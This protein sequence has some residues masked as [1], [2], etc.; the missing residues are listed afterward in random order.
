MPWLHCQWKPPT[1][2]YTR[3]R[4]FFPGLLY[5]DPLYCLG[6]ANCTH[7]LSIVNNNTPATSNPQDCHWRR[8][9]RKPYVV[10]NELGGWSNPTPTFPSSLPPKHD[11]LVGNVLTFLKICV[12]ATYRFVPILQERITVV[13][14]N[15]SYVECDEL[16]CKWRNPR[17]DVGRR[18][19]RTKDW[20]KNIMMDEI[21]DER[22]HWFGPFLMN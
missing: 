18:G 21:G 1:P 10:Y 20:R 5:T 2:H 14:L 7:L 13:W 8:R 19:G 3:L 12:H 22:E 15:I 11:K 17:R 16:F 9:R 6:L 4:P